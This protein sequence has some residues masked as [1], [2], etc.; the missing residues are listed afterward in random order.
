MIKQFK[1]LFTTLDKHKVEQAAPFILGI[2]ATL[3]IATSI[4]A[5]FP[6][7]N[8]GAQ[9]PFGGLS[10]YV[11]YC[12]CSA[13]IAVTINDL[14]VGANSS[15]ALVYEPGGTQLF[16]YGQ[17]YEEGVWTLGLWTPGGICMYYVGKGCSSYPVAGTMEMVGTSM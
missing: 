14:A 1:K 13:N 16:E 5:L 10:T 8:V 17:I 9:E 7:K 12:T 3:F 11:F 4:F 2:A 6:P 15:P